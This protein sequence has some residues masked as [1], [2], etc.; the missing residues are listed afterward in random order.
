MEIFFHFGFSS[1]A[2][3]DKE[4][5][6]HISKEDEKS[7]TRNHNF[8]FTTPIWVEY[9]GASELINEDDRGKDIYIYILRI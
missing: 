1:G 2:H 4:C 6:S 3:Y 8:S 9:F 5:G 7:I